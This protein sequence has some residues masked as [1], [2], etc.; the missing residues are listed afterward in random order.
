MN[1]GDYVRVENDNGMIEGTVTSNP[2][3]DYFYVSTVTG[4]LFISTVCKAKVTVLKSAEPKKLGT[5]ISAILKADNRRYTAV[6]AETI[7]YEGYYPWY[8]PDDIG[9]SR[10]GSWHE[11]EEF[12]NAEQV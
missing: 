10:S 11:W 12:E 9:K 7:N 2:D 4:A 3:D 1:V 8:I 6:R 5:V